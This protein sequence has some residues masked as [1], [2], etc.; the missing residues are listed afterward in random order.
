MK[1]IKA[2]NIIGSFN[3]IDYQDITMS[4]LFLEEYEVVYQSLQEL[5]RLRKFKKTFDNYELSQ[6]QG[7]I[8]YENWQECEK[9]LERFQ[10]KEKPMKPEA[11]LDLKSRLH[12]ICPYCKRRAIVMYDRYC[13]DCGQKLDWSD[14]KW[15]T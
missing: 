9:E 8:A 11:T 5:K 6:K 7:F 15:Y 14:E 2:L 13:C 12:F 1:E 3:P 4:Q 10:K